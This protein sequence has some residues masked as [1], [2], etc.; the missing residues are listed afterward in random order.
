MWGKIAGIRR[1]RR[2]PPGP[3]GANA[4]TS[5]ILDLGATLGVSR[6]TDYRGSGCE[7]GAARTLMS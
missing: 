5:R 3:P 2:Y 7:A 1:V 4:S 6:A